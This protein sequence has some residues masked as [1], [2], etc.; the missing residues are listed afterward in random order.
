MRLYPPRKQRDAEALYKGY[1][2]IFEML[3]LPFRTEFPE[4][5]R[6]EEFFIALEN[7][8][9]PN[10]RVYE[11]IDLY[12]PEEGCDCH[13]V[14]AVAID[15]QGKP[16]ATIAYGWKSPGYYRKWGIKDKDAKELSRG[17]LD[18]VGVQSEDSEEIL[19]A[20]LYVLAADPKV[21]RFFQKRYRHFKK[22]G[23]KKPRLEYSSEFLGILKKVIRESQ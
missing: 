6:E 19:K 20:F 11:I 15:K 16:C 7:P 18:P 17:F 8:Q 2:K 5:A 12:C 9:L 4:L 10:S 21:K 3:L 13:K 23:P 1:K 14:S 22:F